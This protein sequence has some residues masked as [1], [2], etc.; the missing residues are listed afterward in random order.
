[1]RGTSR[2]FFVWAGKKR[3]FVWVDGMGCFELQKEGLK[4][5]SNIKRKE[6]GCEVL[7]YCTFSGFGVVFKQGQNFVIFGIILRSFFFFFFL[8]ILPSSAFEVEI[9]ICWLGRD[10]HPPTPTP[11]TFTCTYTSPSPSKYTSLPPIFFCFFSPPSPPNPPP[12]HP[13]FHLLTKPPQ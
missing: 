3:G 1:M 7:F 2:Y 5:I 8:K 12:H 9:K 13:S 4:M 11:Y 10:V 6:R